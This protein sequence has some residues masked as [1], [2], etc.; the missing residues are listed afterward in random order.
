MTPTVAHVAQ[1]TVVSFSHWRTSI[2]LNEGTL[3]VAHS[4]KSVDDND[5][6]AF[7]QTTTS[8]RPGRSRYLYMYI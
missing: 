2:A 7:Y 8:W 6:D 4:L 1:A 5:D 3:V